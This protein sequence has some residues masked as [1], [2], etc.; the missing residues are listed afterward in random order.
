MQGEDKSAWT[1]DFL[2][3]R[4]LGDDGGTVTVESEYADYSKLGGYNPNY[5]ES[6]GGYILG[7]YLFPKPT[8][9]GTFQLLGKF[10]QA[11]FENGLTVGDVEYDQTT[12][13]VNLNYIIKQFNARV[14]FF[15]KD[16][17]F[18]AVRTDFKTFGIGVQL[19]M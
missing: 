15:F 8:G 1:A 19:Q 10:G 5:A 3:E 17:G 2:L 9:M 12:T 13:E 7:A 18:S 11:N 14:M 6:N 16:T 4:K